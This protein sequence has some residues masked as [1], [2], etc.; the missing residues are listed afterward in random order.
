M[1]KWSEF[2]YKGNDDDEEDD[3]YEAKKWADCVET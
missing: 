3:D 2:I 1:S